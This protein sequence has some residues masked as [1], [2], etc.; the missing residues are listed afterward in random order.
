MKFKVF[1]RG[2]YCG[3]LEIRTH[4]HH[5]IRRSGRTVTASAYI[6]DIKQYKQ[7]KLQRIQ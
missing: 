5:F 1:A 2:M 4:V 6:Q 3:V 7:L